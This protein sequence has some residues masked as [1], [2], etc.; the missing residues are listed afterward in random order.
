MTKDVSEFARKQ[1]TGGG[2][3][4]CMKRPGVFNARKVMNSSTSKLIGF[5]GITMWLCSDQKF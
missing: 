2:L 5:H 1:V 4:G 3:E